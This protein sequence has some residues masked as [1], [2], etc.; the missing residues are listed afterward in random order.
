MAGYKIKVRLGRMVL[1]KPLIGA[2]GLCGFGPELKEFAD[3]RDI[4][5]ITTKTVTLYPRQGNKPPRIV[6]VDNGVLNSIGLQN[7]GVDVFLKEKLPLLKKL[8]VKFIV[9][10]AAD[11]LEEFAVITRKLR[12]KKEIEAIELNLSCPNVK[13]KRLISQD[14]AMTYQVVKRAKEIF[15][16]TVIAK[17]TPEVTDI[18]EVA[19]GVE[20]GG[21]DA[22]SLVNTFYGLA[23]N[24]D[25][26]KSYL[27]NVYGGYSGPAVKP[28]SL[29]RVWQVSRR[30]KIPVI[31]GGGI[32]DG[33]DAVE[34]FLAGARLVSIGTLLLVNANAAGRVLKGLL[35][36]MKKNKIYNIARFPRM[37]EKSDDRQY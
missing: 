5:A 9:S 8:P 2:S 19:A 31:G 1:D 13:T 21:G 33:S 15:E 17:L 29:Y 7:P 10:I 24:I 6:E 11:T 18:G 26:K 30:V 37:S 16:R 32:F 35:G 23:I 3:L 36:Y 22:I 28:Q 25:T 34:F 20:K 14:K 12:E 4:G 27:G